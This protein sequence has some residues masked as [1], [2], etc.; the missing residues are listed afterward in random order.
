[1]DEDVGGLLPLLDASDP[2]LRARFYDE[3]GLDGIYDPHT[4]VVNA[5]ADLGVR[6]VGVGGGT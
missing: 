1:V 2:A 4:R 5:S 3:I 6:M